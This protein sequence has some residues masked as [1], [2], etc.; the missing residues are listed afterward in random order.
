[1][2]CSSLEEKGSTITY[3]S[4]KLLFYRC[5]LSECFCFHPKRSQFCFLE[6]LET[7][8]NRFF[9]FRD[10]SWTI[11][12]LIISSPVIMH[13]VHRFVNATP[14]RTADKALPPE[15]STQH[16]TNNSTHFH[17]TSSSFFT[18]S[19]LQT[20]FLQRFDYYFYSFAKYFHLSFLTYQ[21]F[22]STHANLQ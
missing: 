8:S 1:M 14:C 13:R 18:G 3:S 12:S 11:W 6:C 21:I 10:L 20:L 22:K 5:P 9:L 16:D 17:L 2:P 19:P 4:R 15:I 7:R